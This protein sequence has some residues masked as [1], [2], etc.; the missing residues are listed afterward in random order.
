M[1]KSEW[2]WAAFIIA[3]GFISWLVMGMPVPETRR[4][5]DGDTFT[6]S[7]NEWACASERSIPRFSSTMILVTKKC[8]VWVRREK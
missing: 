8:D 2:A 4:L 1:T 7:R 5:V 6:L 3:V